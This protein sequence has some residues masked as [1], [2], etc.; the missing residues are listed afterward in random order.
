MGF[1]AKLFGIDS[2]KNNKVV[3]QAKFLNGY[4]VESSYFTGDLYTNSL[5]SSVVH[6]IASYG[7]MIS[8]QHVRGVGKDFEVV[9]DDVHRLLTVKPN[10]YMTPSDLYYKIWTDLLLRSNSYI[11]I[12][13]DKNTGKP[14]ALLPVI[15][16][17]VEMV[18][19]ENL[20]F[21]K[22]TFDDGSKLVAYQGDII[23]NRLYFY[24][25][26]IFGTEMPGIRDDV[27]LLDTMQV[28]LD[29][30]L[31]NS[32]QIKGI[33]KH[34]NTIDP[35]D[36][37][38]QEKLF[39]ESYLSAKNS[40]GIGMIDAKF[41]FIPITYSGK[42]IDRDEMAEI[43]DYVYRHFGVNDKILLSTYTSDE[44][45]AYFEGN[46]S[47]ILNQ[48]CQRLTLAFFTDKEIGYLNRIESSVNQISFMNSSQKVQM[49]KLALDGA[50]Y[51]RNEIRQWFGDGPIPGGDTVQYSKNFTENTG[52]NN[53]EDDDGET[54]KTDSTNTN[55]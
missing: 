32:A 13:R 43:R 7:S 15:S 9:P 2:D 36:L 41:D 12:K 38:K 27:G 25:N 14:I 29:A 18:E 50:L 34:S 37:E 47:P 53:K 5:V 54:N 24:K 23:H 10:S 4:P 26:D 30:S 48:F 52:S 20:L 33:L 11:Y 16:Q 17:N 45:Q 44:W 6:R 40:G 19:I 28:S 35:E 1:F 39:K 3:P 22:F 46:M 31:K 21:Y 51:T 42:I 8:Y 55:S 49:V